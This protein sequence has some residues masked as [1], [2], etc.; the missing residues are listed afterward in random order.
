[1]FGD[2]Q[3]R[4]DLR[5]YRRRGL[6]GDARRVVEFLRG[7]GLE[8][9]TVLEVGGGIGAA[10]TELLRAG[11]SRVVNVELSA[12]YEAAAGELLR[13][14]GVDGECVERRVGDFVGIASE[15]DAAEAVVMIRVVCCYSDYA[16]L[17]DAAA[18]RARRFL[19]YTYPRDGAVVRAAVRLANFTLR[20]G[21]RDFRACV[22]PRGEMLGVAEAQGLRLVHEH[23]G[24]VWR[25][26]AL[27][28]A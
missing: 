13:E 1:M 23:R 15:L 8:G 25:V 11:A 21:G 16:A 19:V 6:P 9:A 26:A 22:H 10:A 2:R 12:G 27:A 5:R 7:E 18:S 28:R 4:R 14:V 17:L 3:A 20:L 24:A